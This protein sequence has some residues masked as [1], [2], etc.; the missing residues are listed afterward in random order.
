LPVEGNKEDG[1][2]KEDENR[3]EPLSFL[4]VAE[5][6]KV[7]KLISQ[8]QKIGEAE[9][10]VQTD[11]RIS[12]EV[13]VQKDGNEQPKCSCHDELLDKVTSLENKLEQL[14]SVIK[15]SNKQPDQEC[16]IPEDIFNCTDPI[17]CSFDSFDE[18]SSTVLHTISEVAS[19]CSNNTLPGMTATIAE[20]RTVNL[21]TASV[22]SPSFS[23]ISPSSVSAIQPSVYDELFKKSSSIS[24]L[25][26]NLVF[27]LFE[28]KELKDSNC[29]GVH[30][31]KSLERD[32]R[33]DL[34]KESIFKKFQVEDKTKAWSACRKAIDSAI[35]KLR[36]KA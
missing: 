36:F 9:V 26:K 34:I 18:E 30:Q 22:I 6:E 12:K 3:K 19:I 15:N 11:K 13:G 14:V 33:M 27:E 20:E 17:T 24:N 7:R 29:S 21:R 5:Q 31:K 23:V 28:A 10:G 16:K 35:R 4:H 25:A 32:P 2:V 1:N 8:Y